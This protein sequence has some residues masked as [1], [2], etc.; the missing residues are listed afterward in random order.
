MSKV[1]PVVVGLLA[2]LVPTFGIMP[3]FFGGSGSS[4]VALAAFLG[5][6][7]LFIA[8]TA[9]PAFVAGVVAASV[10]RLL[11]NGL[12]RPGRLGAGRDEVAAD[13][14]RVFRMDDGQD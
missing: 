9:V 1:P 10:G 2:L 12:G 13:G 3:G 14:L 6:G 7:V 5:W 8:M 11:A 4:S